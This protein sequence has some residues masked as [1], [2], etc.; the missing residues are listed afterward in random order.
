MHQWSTPKWTAVRSIASLAN[1]FAILKRVNEES[2][3]IV[4]KNLHISAGKK[5]S[6]AS[7][8]SYG[9]YVVVVDEWREGAVSVYSFHYAY[10]TLSSYLVLFDTCIALSVTCLLPNLISMGRF[11]N[12]VCYELSVGWSIG[13]GIYRGPLMFCRFK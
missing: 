2:R 3:L 1:I 13:R 5:V 7:R 10:G 11:L 4:G 12:L 6:E 8:S 9:G